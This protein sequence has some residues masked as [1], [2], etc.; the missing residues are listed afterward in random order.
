MTGNQQLHAETDSENAQPN[1]PEVRPDPVAR[2]LATSD[3]RLLEV[4]WLGGT[5]APADVFEHVL[6]LAI[7]IAREGREGRRIGT[8]F[9]VGDHE[10]VLE[11]SRCLILDPIAGHPPE[12]RNITDNDVRE[13]VKELAQLDGGF[14]ITAT[15][16]V[17][18]AARY[19]ESFLPTNHLPLGFGTRHHAAASITATTKAVALVV[20]ES[21]IVRVIANG[22]LVAEI[23]PELWLM[24]R[25]VS[26]VA[27]PHL[28]EHRADNVAV[29]SGPPGVKPPA[30]ASRTTGAANS[31]GIGGR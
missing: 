8:I 27:H 22:T 30:G 17:E 25:F 12:R 18:S 28:V 23:L 26:H 13:T 31:L 1:I 3:E 24:R 15:G 6:E 9:T 20:S 10:R 11:H 21:S 2:R 29:V 16:E 14:V 5:D 7:E 4:S 19:F